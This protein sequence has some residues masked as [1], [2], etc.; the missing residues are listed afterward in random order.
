MC[1]TIDRFEGSAAMIEDLDE[2]MISVDKALLPADAREGDILK[3]NENGCFE[4]DAE[5]T[6][7]RRERI[8][9]MLSRLT[10]RQ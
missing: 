10:A 2:N 4:L 3:K 8:S 9:S 5:A 6:L 7:R 1:W